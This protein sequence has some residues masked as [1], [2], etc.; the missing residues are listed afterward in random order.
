VAGE[1]DDDACQPKLS[2]DLQCRQTKKGV[3]IALKFW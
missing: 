3:V 2:E 1:A